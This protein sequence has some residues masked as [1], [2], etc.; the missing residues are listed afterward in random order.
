[1]AGWNLGNQLEASADGYP[2]ETAYG[3]PVVT[4]ELIKAVKSAGF[5]TVRIPVSWLNYIGDAPYYSIDYSWMTRV[6]QVVDYVIDND[7]YA[8]I[9]VHNDGA[10]S[11]TGSWI[12]TES[13]DQQTILTKFSAVWYQIAYAFQDY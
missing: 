8:I 7:M 2:S 9:N 6:K 10:H 3:N 4:E 1:G 12:T 13:S 5:N 11:V